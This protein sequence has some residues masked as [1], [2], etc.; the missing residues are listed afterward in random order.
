[1]N[2]FPYIRVT[3]VELSNRNWDGYFVLSCFESEQFI[4]CEFTGSI[5]M[6][7]LIGYPLLW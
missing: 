3:W 7:L 2:Q 6:F 5:F 4:L 1:M